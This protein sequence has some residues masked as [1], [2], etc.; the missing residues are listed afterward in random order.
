[1]YL[2]MTPYGFRDSK[3]TM[4]STPVSYIQSKQSAYS[5]ILLTSDFP[6]M[7]YVQ[8]IMKQKQQVLKLRL[9]ISNQKGKGR[10][11]GRMYKR[12]QLD[13]VR[14]TRNLVMSMIYYIH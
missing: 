5:T 4:E 7:W 13:S 11:V 2:E 12:N 14:G 8:N 1:M 9:K 10:R 6:L 3:D